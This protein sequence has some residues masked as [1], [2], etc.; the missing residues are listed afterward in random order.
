MYAKL[1]ETYAEIE[2]RTKM[3][4]AST[5]HALSIYCAEV[6]MAESNN[7]AA[8]FSFFNRMVTSRPLPRNVAQCKGLCKVKK[9]PKIQK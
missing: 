2:T 5:I 8:T 3:K 6:T 4:L 9:I 7:Y 1:N